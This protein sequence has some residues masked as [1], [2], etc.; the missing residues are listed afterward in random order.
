MRQER[1][2]LTCTGQINQTYS[3]VINEMAFSTKNSLYEYIYDVVDITGSNDCRNWY[4]DV[5]IFRILK[6]MYA[7]FFFLYET[8][9]NF[10]TIKNICAWATR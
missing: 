9:Y 3:V 4:V 6:H 5:T 7:Q 1:E 2:I 8:Y 10:E